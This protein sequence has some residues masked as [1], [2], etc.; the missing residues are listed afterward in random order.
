MKTISGADLIDFWREWPLDE[1]WYADCGSVETTPD[2][3]AKDRIVAE[4]GYYHFPFLHEGPAPEL[5]EVEEDEHE[6]PCGVIEHF[7]VPATLRREDR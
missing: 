6:A 1:N 2:G 5:H 4:G 3:V 7:A